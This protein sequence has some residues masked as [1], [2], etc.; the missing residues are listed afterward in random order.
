MRGQA[1]TVRRSGGR[2]TRRALGVALAATLTCW[3]FAVA[4]RAD[5]D[6]ASDYLQTNQVFLAAQTPT[7]TPAERR[8]LS[9]VQVANR[10]GFDIRVAVVGSE[11]D[12]GSI[13]ELW[14]KPRLYARFLGLELSS[15][16]RQRLLVVMPN[17]YGFNWPGHPTAVVYR[18][19]ATVPLGAGGSALPAAAQA[20]VRALARAA[21]VKLAS[22]PT[23]RQTPA[24]KATGGGGVSIALIAAVAVALAI[25]LGLVATLRWRRPARPSPGSSARPR[26][27]IPGFAALCVAAVVVPAVVLVS[28]RHSSAAPGASPASVVTPPPFNWPPGRRPAPAFALRDQHGQPVS[29]QAYRGRP[30]IVTF[31]DPLC[32]NLCPLEAHVLNAAVGAMPAA[33]RPAILAV[34]VDVYANRRADLL[35]DVRKWSLVPQWH[36][37]V[38][39]RAALAAVW[40]QY[41]IG[42][43]VVTKRIAGNTINYIT[44][45]EAAY[46]ID[47]SGHERALFVWPFYP[48][49]L[50]RTLRQV[51]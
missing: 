26:W 28:T 3:V 20:A 10:A 48:Q 33:Q 17:G 35:Q 37:A 51:S 12:L 21:G 50:V 46:V 18:Q 15:I 29:V 2:L 1:Q 24:S 22:A 40:M 31:V 25:G 19:L 23:Q 49:D 16:Y 44:H 6:P 7:V 4:A 14:G 39:S 45:T 34:S 8:L 38:G 41:R 27:A 47:A 13:T 36:W 5:G 30:V 43:S 11:Y 9:V 32:R 42:V